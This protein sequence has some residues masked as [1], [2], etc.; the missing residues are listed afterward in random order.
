MRIRTQIILIISAFV[1]IVVGVLFVR[2]I[3]RPRVV[4]RAVAPDGTEMCIVQRCNW[5]AEPFTTSFFYRRPGSNWGWFYFDHQ[6][7][8]WSTSRVSLNTK[9]GVAVFYRGS[10]QAI[11]FA[12]ETEIYT[13]HRWDRTM[14]GAQSQLP[15]GWS[16]L[17][18]DQ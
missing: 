12:W 5:N 10:S 2:H 8:Y 11:T 17:L 7:S 9:T 3:G 16:P 18:S 14:T 1:V 13:M 6:D 15:A 4:A